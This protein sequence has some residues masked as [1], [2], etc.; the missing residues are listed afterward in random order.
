MLL[1]MPKLKARK[2]RFSS[3]DARKKA[4]GVSLRLKTNGIKGCVL[5]GKGWQFQEVRIPKN[6]DI[7]VYEIMHRGMR[8]ED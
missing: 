1:L 3:D 2:S 4:A 5:R 7:F 8:H 6:V